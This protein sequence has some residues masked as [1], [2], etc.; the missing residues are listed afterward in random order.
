MSRIDFFLMESVK[1]AKQMPMAQARDFLGGL[2]ESSSPQKDK[3]VGDVRRA[4]TQLDETV[5]M[6]EVLETDPHPSQKQK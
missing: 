1:L 2:L 5:R 3:V 6:I 4:F